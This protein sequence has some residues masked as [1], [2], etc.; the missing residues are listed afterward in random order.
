MWQLLALAG[1]AAFAALAIEP[2]PWHDV[3]LVVMFAAWT[4]VGMLL[5]RRGSTWA[6]GPAQGREDLQSRSISG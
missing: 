6:S 4:A 1:V 3:S 2:D 5:L